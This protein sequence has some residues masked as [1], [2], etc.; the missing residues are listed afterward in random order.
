MVNEL[1]GDGGFTG[2]RVGYNSESTALFDLL[3]GGD[4]H[5]KVKI[6]GPPD[7]D[8]RVKKYYH[9]ES[10]RQYVIKT[11]YSFTP[12]DETQLEP[13]ENAMIEAARAREVI[14]LVILGKEG[15]NTTLAAKAK[16]LLIALSTR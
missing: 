13:R 7:L 16:R 15:F 14:G 1:F 2:I 5:K 6:S 9:H 8:N 12:Q 3:S 10:M 11:L 4:G